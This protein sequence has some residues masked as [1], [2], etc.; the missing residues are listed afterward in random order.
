[1]VDWSF[2]INRYLFNQRIVEGYKFQF[3]PFESGSTSEIYLRETI[4]K[5]GELYL[6]VGANCG[7]WAI[8]ASK[9]YSHVVAVEANPRTANVLRKNMMKN[10]VG[11][12]KVLAH[13][14]GDSLRYDT[15]YLYSRSGQA[16]FLPAHL[17]EPGT[18]ETLSVQVKT[19]D[20]LK[21]TPTV[22]KIDTEGFELNVLKGGLDTINSCRPEIIVETHV[23]GDVER[24][25]TLL[26][27]YHWRLIERAPSQ[28]IMISEK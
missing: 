17:G 8:P 9:Y 23:P 13:A 1:M 3:E 6:D 7:S 14:L 11:N 19:L 22:L 16:S 26:P 24:V 2:I 21:L 12:M 25:R 15:L 18:G 20:S 5:R 4:L 27:S 28:T 10:H